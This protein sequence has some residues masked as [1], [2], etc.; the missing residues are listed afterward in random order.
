M[1]ALSRRD[2]SLCATAAWR[3]GGCRLATF[4]F[5]G[6]VLQAQ[7]N[8][9]SGNGWFET[10]TTGNFRDVTTTVKAGGAKIDTNGFNANINTVLAHDSGLA[11]LPTAVLPRAARHADP[12]WSEHLQWRDDGQ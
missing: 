7:A 4:N 10:A 3:H 1:G 12:R 9:T 5:N 8:Q 11:S 6:G 2:V